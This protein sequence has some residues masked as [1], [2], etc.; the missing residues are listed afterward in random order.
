MMGLAT[1]TLA[2]GLWRKQPTAPHQ[3]RP[4][5]NWPIEKSLDGNG[6]LAAIGSMRT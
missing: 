5:E 2:K 3:G 4:P 1:M 6:G